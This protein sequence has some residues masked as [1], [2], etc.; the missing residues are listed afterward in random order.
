MDL[1]SRLRQSLKV[2]WWVFAI[3]GILGIV[4]GLAFLL[5]PEVALITM[6]YV[7]A[8]FAIADG[9]LAIYSAFKEKNVVDNWWIML[10]WGTCM[11]LI[12]ILTIVNP[13]IV[14]FVFAI[15]LAVSLLFLG[16][17]QIV[18]GNKIKQE[19]NE[20]FMIILGI[21]AVLFAIF[22]IV[23]PFAGLLTITYTISFFG[24]FYGILLIAFAFKI[25][26]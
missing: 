16:I 14:A 19:T 22:F 25:K 10:V 23:N 18:I 5:A 7:F 26:K 6:L 4:L 20:W 21:L 12:G 11:V 17:W 1:Q 3:R 8:I 2:N 15:Y 24:L 13:V 9:L